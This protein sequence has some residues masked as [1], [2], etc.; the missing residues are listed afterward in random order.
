M[1]SIKNN[2][3]VLSLIGVFLLSVVTDFYFELSNFLFA[4]TILAILDK[5]GKGLVLRELIVLHTIFIC[6]IMPEVGYKVYT[7]QNILALSFV[8][9]MFIPQDEYFGYV[10][11]AVSAF[12]AAMCFPISK[13][14]VI[15]DEGGKI[16]SLMLE[17]KAQL[18][19]F[20]KRGIVIVSVGI[21]MLY[22]SDHL[23]DA[24]NFVAILFFFS[25]FAGILYIYFAPNFRYKNLLLMLFS[26]FIVVGTIESGVFTL[27]AY[28]GITLFSFLFLGRKIAL[29][30]KLIA[31]ILG[32]F[33]L[34]LIQNV[35][36]AYRNITW[37]DEE[38]SGNKYQ[39]FGNI[40]VDKITHLD[41]IFDEKGFFPIYMRS[42]QG[43]N[44]ARV[45]RR[46]PTVQ[47]FDHGKRLLLVGASSLVPRIFWPDKPQAG[48]QESMR[49]FTGIEIYGWSTNVSPLGEAYG[50]FGVWGGIIYM[51]I[52]GLFVRWAY[53][54]VFVVSRK[55]PLIVLWI[56][57]LFYQVTSSM[58]TDTLQI[59][60][61]V[62]KGGFFLWLIYK[63]IPSWFGVAK[64]V[65]IVRRRSF[66]LPEI[67][68]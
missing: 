34:F 28:M 47:D 23:P 5:L 13:N 24:L 67:P 19:R 29:W 60:N 68:A 42:N 50:S 27:I 49:Y 25:S 48:G 51:F 65:K 31:F 3:F 55:L 38:Y 52:L 26:M 40:V 45:M 43:Y 66:P 58:E 37:K 33:S 20:G 61:S 54:M 46:I 22:V 4:I 41:Q 35:K 16:M 53:K 12:S 64:K 2:F 8:K 57:V 62:L 10:L 14:G 44:I 32:F 39:L 15:L 63:F 56:P 18:S 30:K 36:E 59:L 9:Y 6:L 7:Y 17:V 11:P 21:V 1:R